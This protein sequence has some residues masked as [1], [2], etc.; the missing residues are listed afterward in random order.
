MM[1]GVLLTINQNGQQNEFL[2]QIE[3]SIRAY[4]ALIISFVGIYLISMPRKRK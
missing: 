3:T 1:L 2:K 4:W